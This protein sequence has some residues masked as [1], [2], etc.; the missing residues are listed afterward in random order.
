M[1]GLI[2]TEKSIHF[3][4]EDSLNKKIIYSCQSDLRTNHSTHFCLPQLIDFA[5]TGMNRQ[6]HTA[7]ILVDLQK[8]F[9]TLEHG[10]LL[11]KM[12]Y[13]GFRTSVIKCF[14]P[15]F[16][17]KGSWFVIMFF[18][19]LEHYARCTIMLCSWTAPFCIIC[20]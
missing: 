13:F 2:P 4:T 14:S 1:Q 18:L 15:I 19:R 10:V 7:M 12:K 11:E 17:K 8:A 3:Q 5:L 16:Q 9:D 6:I 20:K